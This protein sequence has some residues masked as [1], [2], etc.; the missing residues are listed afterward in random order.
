GQGRVALVSG[1]PGVG[2]TRL[3][4]G[5]TRV[6]QARGAQV[7]WARC[8]DGGGAPAF[9]LWMQALQTLTADRD[10]AA[11]RAEL[12]GRATDLAQ[13][14]PALGEAA[15]SAGEPQDAQVARFR[16][17]DATAYLLRRTA[18]AQPLVL[19]F[20]DL[21]AADPSTLTLLG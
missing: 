2:K 19:V 12:G 11:V 18:L 13:L 16:L 5:L 8:W 10:V 7:V 17:F 1:E 14:L 21:H 6:A 4:D 3:A 20:D 15:L 9:W